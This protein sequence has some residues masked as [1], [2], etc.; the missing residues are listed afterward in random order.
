[1]RSSARRHGRRHL[2]TR[3]EQ[4]LEDLSVQEIDERIATLQVEITRLEEARR[5]T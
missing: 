1:M 4:S 2:L 3:S 5:A